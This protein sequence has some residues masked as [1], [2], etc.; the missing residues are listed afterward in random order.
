MKKKILVLAD[1]HQCESENRSLWTAKNVF[2]EARVGTGAEARALP[3]RR[4]PLILPIFA[5]FCRF[6]PTKK[7]FY[8]PEARSQKTHGSRQF[9][10]A[11]GWGTRPTA[12]QRLTPGPVLLAFV[13]NP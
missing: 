5:S 4:K 6:L 9:R 10:A 8:E 1:G 13:V 12:V 2:C 11:P 7:R 3:S